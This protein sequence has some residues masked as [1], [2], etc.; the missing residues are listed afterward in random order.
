MR[1]CS[2]SAQNPDRRFRVRLSLAH[3]FALTGAGASISPCGREEEDCLP[4][5]SAQ[6]RR[7][8]RDLFKESLTLTGAVASASPL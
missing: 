8:V 4:R 2:H 6:G 7:E 3:S 5:R 1:D